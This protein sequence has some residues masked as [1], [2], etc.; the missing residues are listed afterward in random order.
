MD[1]SKPPQNPNPTSSEEFFMR[2]FIATITI[3][4]VLY[5]IRG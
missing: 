4:S 2:V 1:F 3:F 5:F